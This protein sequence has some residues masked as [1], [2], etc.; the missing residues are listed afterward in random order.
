VF[1]RGANRGSCDSATSVEV[2]SDLATTPGENYKLNGTQ[3]QYNFS[4]KGLTS[5]EYRIY[6]SLYDGTKRYVDLC[7]TK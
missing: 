6:A 7:L 5:G 1:S 3:Y 2:P 4:T